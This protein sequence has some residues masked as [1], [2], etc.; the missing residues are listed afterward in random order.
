[1]GDGLTVGL[2]GKISRAVKESDTALAVGS[3]SLS[4]LGTPVLLAWMEAAACDAM[5]GML[6]EGMTT[7]GTQA[8]MS[9]LAPT[10]VGMTVGVEAELVEINGRRISFHVRAWDERELIGECAHHRFMVQAEKFSSRAAQKRNESGHD[11]EGRD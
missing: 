10:P 11:G 4:V 5:G 3:G 6:P 7:V 1:M 9:H 8:A 2:Q